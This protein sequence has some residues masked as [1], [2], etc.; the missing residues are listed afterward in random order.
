MVNKL[1]TLVSKPPVYILGIV[2]STLRDIRPTVPQAQ[3]ESNFLL[4]DYITLFLVLL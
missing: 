3:T 2:N 1:Y 4:K